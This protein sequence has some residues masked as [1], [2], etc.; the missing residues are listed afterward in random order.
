MLAGLVKAIRS[1]HADEV[2]NLILQGVDINQPWS[3]N[4]DHGSFLEGVT[5]LMIAAAAPKS[6]AEI[7]SILVDAGA[8]IKAKSDGEVT[9]VWYAAG[10]G[11]GYP[12]TEKNLAELGPDHPYLNWGAG[13]ADRLRLLLDAGGD[14]N[15]HASN[16]RSALGEACSVGNADSVRLLLEHQASVWPVK[17]KNFRLPSGTELI[18]KAVVGV[19]GS[20]F[21]F[22]VVPLFEAARGGS[23][24]C[25]KL[26]LEAGFPVDYRSG[27][28]TALDGAANLEIAEMLIEN[29]LKNESGAFGFDMI[30]KAFDDERYDVAKRLL[31]MVL[32]GERQVVLQQKLM[33][34]SG[35][36]MSPVAVKILLD[37][38]ADASI[39]DSDFG[40]ALHAA[41]WQGDGNGGREDHIVEETLELLIGAGADIE[42]WNRH[43]ATPL[44]EAVDGDWDSPTSVKV[45]L[46]HGAKIEVTNQYGQTPLMLAANSGSLESVRLLLAAG[47][48]R[49]TCDSSRKTALDYANESRAIWG[50]KLKLPLSSRIVNKLLKVDLNLDVRQAEKVRDIDEMIKLLKS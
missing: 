9:A 24:E 26:I 3:D 15:D 43:G 23:I 12:L 25:V 47:A 46:R 50:S 27:G 21:S 1:G 6:T 37:M 8:N 19:S 38:G 45:L 28:V 13:G 49:T 14:P 35:V 5:P 17:H 31:E 20:N 11:T 16:S 41:C 39:P 2:R 40:S 36:Y 29:G 18:I 48:N 44:L 33:M 4:I 10:G 30:V 7:V 22:E 42:M 34:C 32:P